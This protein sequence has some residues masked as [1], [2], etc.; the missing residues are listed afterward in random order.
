[1]GAS[2]RSRGEIRRELFGLKRKAVAFRR[3]G[4]IEEAEEAL[5]MAKV[6]EDQ[7]AE[8][9]VPKKEMRA[10]TDKHVENEFISNFVH[11]DHA[12][13]EDL[14]TNDHIEH[15]KIDETVHR[16][17]KPHVD[18][19]DSVL[20]TVSR[21]DQSSVRQEILAVKRKA[22]ALERGEIGRS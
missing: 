13:I 6:L 18:E 2:R 3:Q 16:N 19:S 5:K 1:M 21:N 7:L 9:E 11:P 14:G 17:N 22:V 4:E 15:E 12:V 20:A 10:E 8:M